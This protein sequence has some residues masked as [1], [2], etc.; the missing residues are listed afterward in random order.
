LLFTEKLCENA[1]RQ[2]LTNQKN[3]TCG[4]AGYY[5][6]MEDFNSTTISKKWLTIPVIAM[7]THLLCREVT[8]FLQ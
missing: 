6:V 3:L 8:P 1:K 5:F 4:I 7:M 2:R